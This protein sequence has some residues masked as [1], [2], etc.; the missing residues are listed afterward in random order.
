MHTVLY[1][2]SKPKAF[3]FVSVT[4]YEATFVTTDVQ[5]AGTTSSVLL[6]LF[7]TRGA[8]SE[9]RVDKVE[10]RFERGQ[11][12]LVKVSSSISASSS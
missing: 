7:G 6:M 12:N 8:S 3:L 5:N 1:C 10:D 4:P 2:I 9:Y 11:Q